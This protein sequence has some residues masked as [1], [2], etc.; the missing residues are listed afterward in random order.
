MNGDTTSPKVIGVQ[1]NSAHTFS[2][3]ASNVVRLIENHGVEGDAHAGPTDQHLFHIRRFGIH[4]NLRQVH[5]I[6]AELLDELLD[7]GH[8]VRPGDLGENLTTRNVD[9]LGLPE[10]TLLRLGSEAVIEI[11]GL[12]NPCRQI[13]TFQ[14]GLREHCIETGPDGLIRKGGV[15]GIVLKGGEVRPGDAVAVELPP[16]P[17]HPLRYRTPENDARS[18][19]ERE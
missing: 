18:R 19:A 6:H 11:T 9:L 7:K 1:V 3:V 16:L 2:K 14:P 10:G 8:S 15:M 13:D 12:R 17:H 5:V 4:P